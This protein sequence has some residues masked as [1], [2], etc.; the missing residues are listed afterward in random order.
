ME[1]APRRDKRSALDHDSR[2]ITP[3]K[4][5]AQPSLL[6]KTTTPGPGA[7]SSGD[8]RASPC[9]QPSQGWAYSERDEVHVPPPRQ[10]AS[11]GAAQAEAQVQQAQGRVARVLDFGGPPAP[12]PAPAPAAIPAPPPPS[13][14]QR[15]RALGS[16][17]AA[18]RLREQRLEG[19]AASFFRAALSSAWQTPWA[20]QGAAGGQAAFAQRRAELEGEARRLFQAKWEAQR[21][22]LRQQAEAAAAAARQPLP[23]QAPP[24]PPS[25]A[26]RP[27]SPEQRARAEAHRRAALE[28]QQAAA[29]AQA[30]AFMRRALQS[31]PGADRVLH[32]VNVGWEPGNPSSSQEQP[33]PLTEMQPLISPEQRARAEANRQ[34]ALARLQQRQQQQAQP[35]P[36]SPA[37]QQP[38][39]PE[40][41][42]RAEASRQA[43]LA[44][45]RERERQQ[46]QA[47][48]Q[49]A[50]ATQPALAVASTQ[51]AAALA[52]TQPNEFDFWAP[53]PA[54]QEADGEDEEESDYELD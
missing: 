14:E 51:P 40:Q 18:L 36:S 29:D 27:L 35:T 43:A 30:A 7:G 46:A 31:V 52:A 49:T 41:R 28:R 19:Q 33:T 24:P 17:Q 5:T 42:A 2:V 32:L 45:R 12:S 20:Q 15:Q 11:G 34:V 23:H 9:S 3:A 47:Q 21:E 38:I 1:P 44:R 54:T 37:Q 13:P 8:V 25:S 26:P 53:G 4:R 50:A 39:S 48:A 6:A 10:V 22:E 16:R